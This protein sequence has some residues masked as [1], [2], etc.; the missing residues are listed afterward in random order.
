MNSIVS[1]ILLFDK[2]HMQVKAAI[3]W[4]YFTVLD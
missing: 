3:M 2:G 1:K 4:R